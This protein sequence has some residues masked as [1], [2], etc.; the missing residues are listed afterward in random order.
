M[1]DSKK[2]EDILELTP[3]LLEQVS[4]GVM[5]DKAEELMGALI[6]ALKND[7]KKEHD[8]QEM[9]DFVIE[10]WLSNVNFEGVTADDVTEYVKSHW[11]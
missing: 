1:S 8:Q 4:G 9:I 7:T 2:S 11:D 3:E 6:K 10:H 5:N